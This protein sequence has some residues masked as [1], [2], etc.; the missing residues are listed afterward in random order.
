MSQSGVSFKICFHF[1]SAAVSRFIIRI[2][3]AFYPEELLLCTYSRLRYRPFERRKSFH[4]CAETAHS[5]ISS[6]VFQEN[7]L[8]NV[9]VLVAR[10]CAKV[11]E[12]QKRQ[13]SRRRGIF[14]TSTSMQV[15][16][17][18]QTAKLLVTIHATV[19]CSRVSAWLKS[20]G[21]AIFSN[22]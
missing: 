20:S 22:I 16:L 11:L 3:V 19:Y 14:C 8:K 4:V 21:L 2:C 17:I 10:R 13:N 18:V 9:P 15:S 6:A 5:L 1:V 12:R 7:H